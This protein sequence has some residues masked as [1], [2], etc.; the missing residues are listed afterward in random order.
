LVAQVPGDTKDLLDLM[1]KQAT[2]KPNDYAVRN[3]LGGLVY[4]A[5][6]YQQAISTLHMAVRR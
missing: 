5:G 1:Q 3:T 6:Q 4:R 2:K